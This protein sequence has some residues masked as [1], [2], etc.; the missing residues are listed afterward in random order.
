MPLDA[1]SFQ[2]V[3]DWIGKKCPGL[4]CPVCQGRQMDVADLTVAVCSPGYV[5]GAEA[6]VNFGGSPP[7][8]QMI[9]VVC[10]NCAYILFFSAKQMG[11]ASK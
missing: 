6:R 5:A 10:Q 4:T 2:I 3:Q 8:M 1:S 7:V 9:P 11:V